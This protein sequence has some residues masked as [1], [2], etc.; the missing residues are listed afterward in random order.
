MYRSEFLAMTDPCFSNRTCRVLSRRRAAMTDKTQLN[1]AAELVWHAA[2]CLGIVSEGQSAGEPFPPTDGKGATPG[3]G[4]GDPAVDSRL[5][6]G[7]RTDGWRRR[8]GG[9]AREPRSKTARKA[10]RSGLLDRKIGHRRP[11]ITRCPKAENHRGVA[12]GTAEAAT[13]GHAARMR[14]RAVR[15]TAGNG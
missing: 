2:C 7:D 12:S 3:R 4:V 1:L 11:S 6:E 14:C 10:C 8:A 9:P 5:D 13:C 15:R